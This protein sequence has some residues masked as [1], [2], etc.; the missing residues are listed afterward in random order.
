MV[1]RINTPK[2]R[3]RYKYADSGSFFCG[4]A[5]FKTI[6]LAEKFCM[7][8]RINHPDAVIS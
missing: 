5:Y 4:T 3:I 7:R 8:L 2:F 6:E 1:K